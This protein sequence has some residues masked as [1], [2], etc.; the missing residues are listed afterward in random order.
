MRVPE[1]LAG[2]WFWSHTR[3]LWHDVEVVAARAQKAERLTWLLLTVIA[4]VRL[5]ALHTQ[6]NAMWGERVWLLEWLP[7]NSL[8]LAIGF[9]AS[10]I[11]ISL[12]N[13]LRSSRNL[14]IAGFVVWLLYAAYCSSFGKLNHDLYLVLLVTFGWTLLS[15]SGRPLWDALVLRGIQLA[16]LCIYSV[17]GLWKILWAVIELVQGDIS[18]FNPLAARNTLIWHYSVL[19]WTP[20]AQWAHDHYTMLWIGMW[21]AI[22][23]EVGAVIAFFTERNQRMW[24]CLLIALHAGIAVTMNIN[25]YPAVAMIAVVLVVPNLPSLHRCK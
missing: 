9:H 25:M 14:R 21:I 5:S 15:R 10:V 3:Q 20:A 16:M 22:F 19:E 11:I 17:L 2:H 12:A 6:S 1:E 8:A 23:I 24:G 18:M 13:L 4:V 7:Q